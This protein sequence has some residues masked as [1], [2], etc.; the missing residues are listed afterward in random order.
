MANLK[1]TNGVVVSLR[2]AGNYAAVRRAARRGRAFLAKQ[3]LARAELETWE[4]CLVEAGNNAVKHARPDARRHAIRF[5]LVC[6]SGGVEARIHDHTPGFDL[7]D[8]S[9]LPPDEAE[10]GRGLFLLQS[11]TDEMEYLRGDQENCLVLRR[12]HAGAPSPPTTPGELGAVRARLA[13]TERVLESMTEELASSYESLSAIFR[14]VAELSQAAHPVEFA[15]D[16]LGELITIIEADWY[17]FRILDVRGATLEVYAASAGVRP[18]PS[19]RWDEHPLEV[20]S[21]ELRAVRQ[22]ADVWFDASAPLLR[23]DPLGVP[24]AACAGLSHPVFGGEQPIGVLTVGRHRSMEP[25]TAGQVNVVQTFADFLGLQLVNGR[26]QEASIQGRLVTRE[27]EI[28]AAIQ[29]SLLPERLPQPPGFGL[30]GRC[31]T[32]RQVGGDFYDAVGVGAHGLLLVMADVMG[33]GVPAAMFAAAFRSQLRARTDLASR[34]GMF[35]AWLNESLYPDLN[36]VDMFITA[37]LVYVDFAA[38]RVQVASAGHPPLLLAGRSVPVQEVGA[39]GLPLG[40]LPRNSYSETVLPL[41]ASSALFLFTDGITEA[42]NPEGEFFGFN[43]VRAW[44]EGITHDPPSAAGA[45]DR[46][47]GRLQEF[48]VADVPNDD[49]TLLL[50]HEQPEPGNLAAGAP[51]TPAP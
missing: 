19:L 39:T 20:N 32:A 4:L 13:E 5:D 2:A 3:G 28:A 14:F 46:L 50:L 49:Q 30:V 10:A 38:R 1:I 48:Q 11:L 33:K 45:C 31:R 40:I 17:V 22:R 44:I 6:R 23:E 26:L 42:R 7:P 47:L 21:V 27:L 41:P 51:E 15:R 34:P 37:Q 16:R 25:F 36:R 24:E 18:V 43:A 8:H 12:R 35:L 9:R 29:R